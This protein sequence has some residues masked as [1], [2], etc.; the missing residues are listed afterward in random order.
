MTGV[1]GGRATRAGTSLPTRRNLFRVHTSCSTAPPE[2]CNP[3]AASVRD[4]RARM[5][6]PGGTPAGLVGASTPL[7][8]EAESST[9]LRSWGANV[10]EVGSDAELREALVEAG[11][12]TVSRAECSRGDRALITRMCAG[13]CRL[14]RSV[15][16]K[17][18]D[19]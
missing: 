3:G 17:V 14:Q 7:P 4:S 9:A 10:R 13:C 18:Q 11:T 19:G 15:V 5:A 6:L 16:R 8:P 2:L 12:Q 1:A